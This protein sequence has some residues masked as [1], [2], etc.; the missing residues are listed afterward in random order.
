M[1]AGVIL[2]A[3]RLESLSRLFPRHTRMKPDTLLGGADDHTPLRPQPEIDFFSGDTTPSQNLVRLAVGD[4]LV[5]RSLDP[6][7]FVSAVLR[8][9][10]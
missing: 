10:S 2:L 8:E 9:I 3:R 5:R 6:N 4:E 7:V 1:E